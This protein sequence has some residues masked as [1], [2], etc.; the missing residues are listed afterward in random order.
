MFFLLVC[1]CVFSP[2][3]KSSSLTDNLVFEPALFFLP[4]SYRDYSKILLSR[5]SLRK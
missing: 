2:F 1:V 5:I 3:P 4:M